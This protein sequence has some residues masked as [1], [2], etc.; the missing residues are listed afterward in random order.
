MK[1]VRKARNGRRV[2]RMQE[3]KKISNEGRKEVL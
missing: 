2:G 1:E 3:G